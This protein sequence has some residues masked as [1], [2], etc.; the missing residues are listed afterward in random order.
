MAAWSMHAARSLAGDYLAGLGDRW[1][2]VRAVGEAAENLF[3]S[4]VIGESIAVAAW[5]HDLGY[6]EPIAVTGLHALDGARLLETLGAPQPVVSLVAF[7]SGAESEA[8]ERGLVNELRDFAWPSQADLDVLTFL[9]LTVGRSGESIRVAERLS[10]ILERYAPA[11]PVHRAVRRS[12]D[13]LMESAARG[14]HIV[15]QPM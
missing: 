6:A 7:H 8:A 12:R 10:E 13:S 3:D 15:G 5:L 9:D 4:G 14:A 2:H 1:A 11:H